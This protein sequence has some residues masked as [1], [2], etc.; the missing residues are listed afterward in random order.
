MAVKHECLPQ[1]SLT[2]ICTRLLLPGPTCKA[3]LVSSLRALSKHRH[4]QQHKMQGRPSA[5]VCNFH[6]ML[7]SNDNSRAECGPE[8]HPCHRIHGHSSGPSLTILGLAQFI[9]ARASGT[10]TI[11]VRFA[12]SI[13][14]WS[15]IQG[16][17]SMKSLSGS[18]VQNHVDFCCNRKQFRRKTLE[19]LVQHV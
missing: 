12:T 2:C 19:W 3:G 14:R 8:D 9:S 1:Q 18:Q 13:S 16:A 5:D 7:E 11:P 10:V 17:S 15:N 6:A 4:S